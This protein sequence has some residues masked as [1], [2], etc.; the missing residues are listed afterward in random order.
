MM[1]PVAFH[2]V[3]QHEDGE[4][5][6]PVRRRRSESGAAPAEP[7]QIVETASA[8]APQAT[9]FDDELPKRT[10]PR[11]RRSAA[12]DTSPLQIVE[13]SPGAEPADNPPAS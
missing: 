8:A 11:R 5:H 1:Q 9:A 7:L 2:A 6:R 10:K 12:V 4:A 3:S 13:T